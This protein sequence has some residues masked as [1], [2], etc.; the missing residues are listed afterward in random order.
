[1]AT[2][3][4]LVQGAYDAN[5]YRGQAVDAAQRRLGDNL[6]ETVGKLAANKKEVDEVEKKEVDATKKKAED[7]EKERLSQLDTDFSEASE[8]FLNNGSLDEANYSATHDFVGSWKDGYINGTPK[9]QNQIM[10]RLSNLSGDVASYKSTLSA[11][12]EAQQGGDF[13]NSVSSAKKEWYKKLLN[14]E[15]TLSPKQSEGEDGQ[16]SYEMGIVNE[17][18]EWMSQSALTN[19]FDE[20]LIDNNSISTVQNLGILQTKLG[21]E[22]EGGIEFDPSSVT[23]GINTMIKN[24]NINSLVHDE[25]LGDGSGTFA[26]NLRQEKNLV[27][28]KFEDL[29]ISDQYAYELDENKDGI[30]SEGELSQEDIDGIVYEFTNNPSN[31]DALKEELKKYF[32]QFAK[33]NYEKGRGPIR[34]EKESTQESGNQLP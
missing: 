27:N 30:I 12:A 5:K 6:N 34:E 10:N 8:K 20:G 32:I 33:T 23:G 26:D 15:I 1:M 19:S 29:G 18:G 28:L 13:S 16:Q 17:D 31:K 14:G 21:K 2:D 3:T 11:V 4:T 9:E 22:S 25:I 24:G 7:E